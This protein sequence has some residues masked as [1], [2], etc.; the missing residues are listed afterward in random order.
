MGPPIEMPNN[1]FHPSL[2]RS[3][4]I[5][6]VDLFPE[7]VEFDP[8]VSMLSLAPAARRLKEMAIA[9]GAE[10][11]M[12]TILSHSPDDALR[13][14]MKDIGTEWV[15]RS[16][17]AD[18]TVANIRRF[19]IEKE[20]DYVFISNVF[21]ALGDSELIER[22]R[23]FAVA[24]RL[25]ALEIQYLPAGAYLAML[26]KEVLCE[27]GNLPPSAT[28]A[29][30]MAPVRV[31]ATA[32][33]EA[34]VQ[35][36]FDLRFESIQGSSILKIDPVDIPEYRVNSVIAIEA[37]RLAVEHGEAACL[38]ESVGLT[39]Y[40]RTKAVWKGCEPSLRTSEAF[41]GLRVLFVSIASG[42]SG[43]EASLVYLVQGLSALGV[44]CHALVPFNGVFSR[45]LATAG[46]IM[47]CPD[48]PLHR[49]DCYS[50]TI[51]ESAVRDASPHVV[52]FNGVERPE[53]MGVFSAM[54]LPIIQH[55]RLHKLSGASRSLTLAARAIA[56]SNFV[57][58]RV[59]ALCG[60]TVGCDTIYNGVPLD[61]FHP[62]FSSQAEAREL[63]GLSNQGRIVLM[64]GR[65]V[66]NKRHDL[67]VEAVAPLLK[68]D[69]NLSVVF[70]GEHET[71]QVDT[72][73]LIRN[74]VNELRLHSRFIFKP[75]QED[76]RYVM[77]A[78]DLMILP[79]EDEPFARC[80]L[81]AMALGTPVVA[82][83]SGGTPEQI[84]HDSTG[85]LFK[86][87]CSSELGIQLHK[88]LYD[89]K[90]ATELAQGA[91]AWVEKSDLTPERCARRTLE[92]YSTVLSGCC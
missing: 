10:L 35:C 86:P 47:H 62:G 36:P 15:D 8:A 9:A 76:V 77:R 43:A 19:L 80:I 39:I 18:S 71:K 90:R 37:V 75:F 20:A 63:L 5:L 30:L 61:Q 59:R 13:A 51:V 79:S 85:L 27:L 66:P 46:A 83:R 38:F 45:K 87:G 3:V 64:V 4:W 40:G 24:R 23:E 81:E 55:V 56:V 57:A 16:N 52:H 91:R 69:K 22:V 50:R 42:F 74:R 2:S 65:F 88:M 14:A 1:T 67:L 73:L 34:G 49:Y 58:E 25:N 92:T 78:A 60:G 70:I 6:D 32:A 53:F 21:L 44:S 12:L 28:E 17:S 7:S 84:R 82:A 29:D 26:S 48:Y 11:R 72:T 89:R 41:E 54:S 33:R 68:D 31:F